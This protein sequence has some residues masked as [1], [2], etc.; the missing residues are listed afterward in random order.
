[1]SKKKTENPTPDGFA[2]GARPICAFCN[3]PWTDDMIELLAQS[4]IEE[5]YYGGV[6]KCGTWVDIDINC[7]SCKR[8]IYRKQVYADT[9]YTRNNWVK[10][11]P[12]KND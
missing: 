7:S 9:A 2:P 10:M 6:E 5:G 3:A 8:L 1:M 11:E 12:T 4:E